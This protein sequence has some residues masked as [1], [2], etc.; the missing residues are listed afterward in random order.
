M[1]YLDKDTLLNEQLC[2]GS[3][4]LLDVMYRPVASAR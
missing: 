1:A 3:S 4:P 2:V